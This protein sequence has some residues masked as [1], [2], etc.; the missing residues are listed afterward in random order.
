MTQNAKVKHQG[1]D[2]KGCRKSGGLASTT[3]SMCGG[4]K[5][6]SVSAKQCSL[7]MISQEKPGIQIHE[8]NL[9]SLQP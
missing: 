4:Q 7:K 3:P 9:V 6:S 8:G 5:L 2:G 1:A